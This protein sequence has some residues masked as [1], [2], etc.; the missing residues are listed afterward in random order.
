MNR[1]TSLFAATAVAAAAFVH[2]AAAQDVALEASLGTTG[3]AGGG[4]V[5]LTRYFALRGSYNFLEFDLDEQEYDGITYSS[6]LD[7]STFSGFVDV[8]PFG[9]AFTLT[10]GAY[11]GEK[12]IAFDATPTT[13]VEIG[14]MTFTP[15][16]VGMLIGTAEMEETA[17]YIGIGY[18]NSLHTSGRWSFFAR[19][20]VMFTGSPQ[21]DL[22]AE[23]GDLSDDP[24]FQAELQEEEDNIQ[25]DVDDYEYYPVL[26]IGLS[27]KL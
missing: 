11:F 1:I 27:A 26:N 8:H 20:G 4:Q 24:D 19:A 16:Q 14:D 3:I 6:E 25:G 21:I 7:F 23:G 17:P 10:G 18:D 2:P 13:D 22:I 15:E 9:N 12:K 5:G